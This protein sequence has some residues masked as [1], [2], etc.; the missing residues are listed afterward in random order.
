MKKE[1]IK[2]FVTPRNLSFFAVKYS[3]SGLKTILFEKNCRL[4]SLLITEASEMYE[5]RNCLYCQMNLLGG[6]TK[7]N[8]ARM[9]SNRLEINFVIIRLIARYIGIVNGCLVSSVCKACEHPSKP[10]LSHF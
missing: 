7:F 10:N 4:D 8:A 6:A 1:Q 2:S 9:A 5:N 3:K